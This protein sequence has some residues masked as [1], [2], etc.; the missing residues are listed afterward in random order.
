MGSENLYD[1][2]EAYVSHAAS[3]I[4]QKDI[5]SVPVRKFE[6]KSEEQSE[7]SVDQIPRFDRSEIYY[8]A[9]IDSDPA[10]KLVAYVDEEYDWELD[11]IYL[12]RALMDIF[13]KHG[14][15]LDSWKDQVEPAFEK[16]KEDVEDRITKFRVQTYL[17]GVDLHPTDIHIADDA[18]IRQPAPSDLTYVEDIQSFS[19]FNPTSLMECDALLEFNVDATSEYSSYPPMSI[20]REFYLKVLRLYGRS[21]VSM[22]VETSELRTFLGDDLGWSVPLSSQDPQPRST[23]TEDDESSLQRLVELLS[24]HYSK[25]DAAFDYPL[26]AAMDHFETSIEKRVYSRESITFAVIGL[27]ALYTSGRG[28]VS[29]YCAFLLGSAS[30]H[31]DPDN[32]Q[33]TLEGAY[34]NYRN[35]WAHGGSRQSGG[36]EV[37]R[38]LWDYLRGSIVLFSWLNRDTILDKNSRNKLLKKINQAMIDEEKRGE[39]LDEL[40]QLDLESHLQL[41]KRT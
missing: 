37:Q 28:K 16:F 15:S 32:V 12:R 1:A 3:K 27:E 10:Q 34:D 38:R 24:R 13:G 41:P 21:N 19:H 29:T 14:E 40:N 17:Q 36:T 33:S 9:F 30:P 11:Y 31:F 25:Q 4:Q 26:S 5:P 8:H 20:L 7:I 23:L 2:F 6:V 35:S 22:I 18:A 39:F